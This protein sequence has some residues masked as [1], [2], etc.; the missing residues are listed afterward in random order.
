MTS[1]RVGVR[2]G[3]QI[4]SLVVTL[5]VVVG[6]LALVLFERSEHADAEVTLRQAAEQLTPAETP[7]GFWVVQRTEGGSVTTSPDLPS[8]LPLQPDL[9]RVVADGR[10]RQRE[11]DAGDLELFVRTQVRGDDVV[12]VAMDRTA[13]EK[14]SGRLVRALLVAGVLGVLLAAG[15]AVLLARRSLVPLTQ[16]LALQRRFVADASHELRTPLT[17]LST[18]VQMLRRKVRRGDAR[19]D[20]LDEALDGVLAD[21]HALADIV[22]DLLVAA[23]GGGPRAA[24][25]LAAVARAVVAATAADAERRG[26]SLDLPPS[27]AAVVDGS[28]SALRRALTALV[29]N[30]LD[31][32]RSRVEVRVVTAA[33][34]VD[35]VVGDD[36][37]G[38]PEAQA[39][40]LFER[41]SSSRSGVPDE[42]GRRHYGLGLALVSDVAR[43]HGGDIRVEPVASG[44]RFVVSLPLRR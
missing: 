42:W 41:F 5:L 16:A 3:L 13:A 1:P 34:H 40:R 38:I 18:R 24:V 37:P 7:P 15:L 29:D 10:A 39:A 27:S 4:G 36:G 28:E 20:D 31:H 8:A 32:A 44:S 17:L 43:A 6:A 2:L 23:D 9:D 19:P 35:V 33:R 22:D 25:D 30:A 21:T 26:V 11:V 12:Q 14:S